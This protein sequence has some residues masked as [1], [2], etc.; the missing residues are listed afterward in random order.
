MFPILLVMALA[1]AAPVDLLVRGGTVVTVDREMRVLE[2]ASVAIRDGRIEAVI[3]AGQPLPPAREIVDAS[4]RIVI[5]GL[6]NA[7]GHAPMVLLRGAADDMKLMQWLNEVIFPAEAKNV[8]PDFSYWGTLLAGIEMA[9]S[10]TTTFADM[11]YHEDVIARATQTVGLRAVLG[12]TIIGFP[13]P[14]Y[15]TTNDSLAA[16]EAFIVKYKDHAR[17]VPSPGPHAIYTTAIDVV[18]KARDLSVKHGVPFQIHAAESPE[19]DKEVL[20][21]FGKTTVAVLDEAGILG[22]GVILHHA[23]TLSDADM[24]RLAA[25]GVSTSHNPESNMKVASGLARVPDQLAAGVTVGL[26]TDGAA[27]NNNLDMFETMDYVAKI[28]KLV[29]NDPT[30]MPAREVF[31]LATLGGAAALGLGT[32]VGSI[33]PG[34]LADLVVVD[35]EPSQRPVYDVYSHLVYVTKGAS[36]RTTIVQGQV[37]MRDRRMVTVNEDEVVAHALEIQQEV[38]RTLGRPA[39]P[40]TIIPASHAVP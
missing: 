11:Y 4:G 12:Q 25:L 24:K 2:G 27:T 36:V 16:T 29:R 31:R 37:I 20:A 32:R 33:E 28:H 22:P 5:P 17:I 7:H 6:V 3:L 35:V 39:A 8:D 38:L 26:G 30:V 10:G 13:A 14:D 34:K 40:A 18:K 23:T 21:K 19:E 15:K 1:Q 9:K